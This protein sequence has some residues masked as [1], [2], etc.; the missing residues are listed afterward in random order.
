M[1]LESTLPQRPAFMNVLPVF[2]VLALL[3]VF[4]TLGSTFIVER[5]MDIR[6]PE[7]D[8]DLTRYLDP[9]NLTLSGGNAPVLTLDGQEITVLEL[10][11]A[12]QKLKADERALEGDTLLI[13]ADVGLSLGRFNEVV[14]E[15]Q[16][17]GFRAA[18]AVREQGE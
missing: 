8:L 15:V 14:A 1:K 4:L 10:P 2:D 11:D 7:T 16:R 17:A 18:Q 6:L 5:G 12:L 3:L 13:K 9:I